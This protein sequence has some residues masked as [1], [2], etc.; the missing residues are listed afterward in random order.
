MQNLRN[1]FQK[2]EEGVAN[3][4]KTIVLSVYDY[5]LKKHNDVGSCDCDY[6]RLLPEYI[7]LKRE[8][9]KI[10]RWYEDDSY[11]GDYCD[12]HGFIPRF[13]IHALKKKIKEFKQKKDSLKII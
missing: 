5:L 4:Q 11:E 3:N 6:C 7:S 12:G 1:L 13:S 8:L 10:K 9:R 2:V